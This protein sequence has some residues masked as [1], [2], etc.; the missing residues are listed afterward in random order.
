MNIEDISM[1]RQYR[2]PYSE[3][4][5]VRAGEEV[6]ARI[7]LHYGQESSYATIV[8]HKDMAEEEVFDLIMLVDDNVVLSAE[9]PREDFYVTVYRG[10]EIGFY[11]DEFLEEHRRRRG[12]SENGRD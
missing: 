6:I 3:G 7:D 12:L 11:T 1:A 5:L 10:E 2:T 8:L 9:M 4:Y